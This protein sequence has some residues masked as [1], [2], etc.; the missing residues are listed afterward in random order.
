MANWAIAG[1]S[2]AALMACSSPK[3]LSENA[4]VAE[5]TSDAQPTEFK[6]EE[7]EGEAARDFAYAWPAEASAIPALAAHLTER[8]DAALDEQKREWRESVEEFSELGCITC[9]SRSYGMTWE[10]SADTTRMLV[11]TGNRFT[12]TGGAHGNS[13]FEALAWDREAND[14]A[15]AALE[16]VALFASESALENTAFGD[17]CEA[18]LEQRGER[19]DMEISGMNKFE[20]CPS[21]SELVVVPLSSDGATFD[22]VQFLAAPYVAGSFAEGPYIFDIP[23]TAA[24]MDAVKPEYRGAFSIAGE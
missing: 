16:P 15:G 12:Y 1:V 4:G 9:V 3:E 6:D 5:R 11:L 24:L 7:S 23:M 21:V 13:F 18:L 14:G 10:V 2:A 20:S 8:R 19:L 17:Y 22:R